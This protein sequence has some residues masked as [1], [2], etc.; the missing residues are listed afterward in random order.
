MATEVTTQMRQVVSNSVERP[1]NRQTASEGIKPAAKPETRQDLP[2][3][4]QPVPSAQ[5]TESVAERKPDQGTLDQAVDDLN[6]FVQDVRREL[7]FSID[8]DSGETIIKVI[9]SISKEVVRQ[10]PPEEVVDISRHLD[11]RSGVLM[12]AKV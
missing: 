3:P 12:N 7:R 5:Q 11:S 4:R 2:G 9:D 6:S 8:D 10:I 1:N